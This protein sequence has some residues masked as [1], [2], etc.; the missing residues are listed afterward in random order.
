MFFKTARSELRLSLDC[1]FPHKVG[2]KFRFVYF[3][4]PLSTS[5][6]WN[7]LLEASS[8]YL[9]SWKEQE[10]NINY[11]VT[12]LWFCSCQQGYKLTFTCSKVWRHV[13]MWWFFGKYCRVQWSVQ[14]LEIFLRVNRGYFEMG[15]LF[16]CF[17]ADKPCCFF[18]PDNN[19]STEV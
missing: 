14:T 10:R 11:S 12:K 16:T 15:K 9:L 5:D 7:V 2:S 6:L 13:F 1:G 4:L 19:Y 17:L 8:L 18:H 3:V